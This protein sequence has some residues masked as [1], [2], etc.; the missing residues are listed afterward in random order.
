MSRIPY[1]NIK[2]GS[3]S[4]ER[5]SAGSTLP[6][7]QLPFAMAGFIPQTDGR[8]DP[9][10]FH[11][12][13]YS[14]EGIR[15]THQPSPWINDYG[16][17]L[18]L[19]QTGTPES[20]MGRAFS[21]YRPKEAVL[22]PDRLRLHFARCR[23]TAELAPTTRGAYFTMT[24]GDGR[25]PFIS[26]FPAHGEYHY[27]LDAAN[28]RLIGYTTGH[29]HDVAVDFHMYFAVQ[30]APG[31]VDAA[32]TQVFADERTCRKGTA[33]TGKGA[34]I[35]IALNSAVLTA[36]LAIS[37]ISVEQALENLRQD[38]HP[39]GMTGAAREAEAT[40]EEY[41]SR[42][43]V[44][45]DD[46][47]Q[48]RTFYSC[49]YRCF[50]FPHKAFEYTSEG[51]AVHYVPS[52]GGVGK[53]KRYTDLGFWDVY[54][55]LFP[56]FSLIAKEEYAEMLEAFLID[57]HEC[58]WLPR[59]PSIGEVGCMPSTLIDA[60]IA[61]AVVKGIGTPALWEGLLEGML[62]HANNAAPKSCYGRTGVD[63]YLQY[64]YVPDGVANPCVNLTLDAAYG[65]FCIAQVAAALGKTDIEA[66][67]RQRSLNYRHLFDNETGFMRAK[68]TEGRFTEPF[69]PFRWGGPYCESSAWQATF[70]VP[71]DVEGLAAL[72]GG[73]EAMCEK[74]DELFAAPPYYDPA[75]YGFVI[76]E[77]IE[78]ARADFG[79][80]AISNQ[81]SF[82]LPY[83]YAMLGQP[84]KTAYWVER[85]C[86]EAFTA[87]DDGFPGDEDNGTTAAW[88]IFSNL[89]LYP[90]CPGKA[91]Y[92]C[93]PMLV[94]SARIAGIKWDNTDLPVLIPHDAVLKKEK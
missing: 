38:A 43:E 80:C 34:G 25:D 78:M 46:E 45:T 84:E 63:A 72:Y 15:L 64:G 85:L 10:F 87:E 88:Y 14:L 39:E 27:E 8:K 92:V 42:I 56:L 91:E 21:S 54:R 77:M 20:V 29:S 12:D 36:Q 47:L 76:H 23:T 30:F 19:P 53:G 33:V 1:V 24:Y 41:L 48:L 6:L 70:A 52:T 44:T 73:S 59:W 9:W 51:E 40:W 90:V 81:P 37:Y 89:G 61:D 28:D 65:D 16:A 17:L 5:L 79:Q 86:R 7:T 68:D 60:V 69:N 49:M 32:R 26:F 57:Y 94:K 71:H 83:L 50:L 82:H 31:S 58:G 74:L 35:H 2:Q 11:P 67:Y 13:D 93:T 18:F 4:G 22:R 55:T 62:H 66:E 3:H 75:G